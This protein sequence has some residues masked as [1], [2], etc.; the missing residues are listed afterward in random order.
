MQ[1]LFHSSNIML[2]AIVEEC[3]YVPI[4]TFT[5]QVV[6][7]AIILGFGLLVLLTRQRKRRYVCV[8]NDLL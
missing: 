2:S 1:L 8:L 7:V 4:P 6:K 5:S 3:L